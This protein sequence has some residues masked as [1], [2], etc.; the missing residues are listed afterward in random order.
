[1]I[2]ESPELPVRQTILSGIGQT[3][4]QRI[5]FTRK[6]RQQHLNGCIELVWRAWEVF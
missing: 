2:V 6:A 1:M 4:G 5:I 3:H